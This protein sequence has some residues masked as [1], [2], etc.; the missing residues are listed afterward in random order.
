MHFMD[1][2]L[3]NGVLWAFWYEDMVMFFNGSQRR[4]CSNSRY[5]RV[6][7]A[8]SEEVRGLIC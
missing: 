5:G 4:L 6:V 1:V 8:V 3:Y 2:A 7:V